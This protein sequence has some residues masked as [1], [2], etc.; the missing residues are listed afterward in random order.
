MV[1]IFKQMKVIINSAYEQIAP[2]IKLIP[3]IFDKD[4]K[5]VYEGRNTLKSYSV[6]GISV[7]VKNFKKPHLF[8]KLIYTFLRP[9]KAQRSYEYAFQLLERGVNTPAPIAYIEEKI[10][11]LINRSYYISVYEREFTEIREHMFGK[12]YDEP[13][14]K[15]LV[16]FIAHAQQ[17]GVLQKDLSPGNILTKKE[18]DKNIFTLVDINRTE[19]KTELSLK[20]KYKNFERISE[21]PKIIDFMAKEYA[22]LLSLDEEESIK[23]IHKYIARYSRNYPADDL[24]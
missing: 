2:F 22:K 15:D 17:Q 5:V 23:Q 8:N 19:F 9:T 18:G 24:Q 3:H 10:G 11:G 20:E 4:G 14:L 13:F 6:E 21:S 16:Q 7:I 1:L 12:N